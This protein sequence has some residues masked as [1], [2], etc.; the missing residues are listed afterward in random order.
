ML[1]NDKNYA[2]K[3]ILISCGNPKK[4]YLIWY[5]RKSELIKGEKTTPRIIVVEMVPILAAKFVLLFDRCMSFG[6]KA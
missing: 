5:Y 6:E 1:N 4:S 3:V 2:G